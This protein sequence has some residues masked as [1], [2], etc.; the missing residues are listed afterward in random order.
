MQ[1]L[2]SCDSLCALYQSNELSFWA[3]SYLL[4]KKKR[5]RELKQLKHQ[6]GESDDGT[7]APN[8]A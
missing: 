8:G 6:R 5:K 3:C 2:S 1:S 4:E 7:A